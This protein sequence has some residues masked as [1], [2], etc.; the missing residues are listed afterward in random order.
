VSTID[1]AEVAPVTAPAAVVSARDAD[2]ARRTALAAM[3]PTAAKAPSGHCGTRPKVGFRPTTPHQAAG[4]RMEPPASVP[5]CSAPKPAAAAAPAPAELPPGVWWK[6]QGLRVMPCSGQSPGVFQPNSVVVVLPT[7]T[8]PALRRAMAIGASSVAAAVS[9]RREPRRVGRPAT[10]T[11]SLMVT[12]PPSSGPIGR[13]ARQRA[14]LSPAWA[15]ECG[16][17]TAKALMLGLR[18]ATRSVTACSTSTGERA[19]RA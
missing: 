13:P 10:S 14:A 11:R 8:A 5:K 2:P 12:G 1:K 19:L 16:F 3:T 15:R 9:L 6:F 4:R 18:R 7:M 17:I